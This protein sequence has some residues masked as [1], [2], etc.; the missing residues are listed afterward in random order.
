[1]KM[2]KN[3]H[4]EASFQSLLTTVALYEI[5]QPKCGSEYQYI[6]LLC[7]LNKDK[8]CSLDAKFIKAKF[9]ILSNYSI[10]IWKLL[11]NVCEEISVMNLPSWLNYKK[12]LYRC[13]YCDT[14]THSSRITF[15][16]H[17]KFVLTFDRT[18]S[19][20]LCPFCRYFNFVCDGISLL[21]YC[22]D[23]FERSPS[24][25]PVPPLAG[26]NVGLWAVV[27]LRY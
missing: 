18:S 15:L 14:Q 6:Q 25:L 4:Y 9:A 22:C 23:N 27:I 17:L 21:E 19:A 26:S 7:P 13:S 11:E 5:K 2:L 12:K 16:L 10:Q 24:F 8:R 1:M 3:L 20:W